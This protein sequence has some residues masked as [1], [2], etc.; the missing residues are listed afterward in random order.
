MLSKIP[1]GKL[2]PPIVPG[3]VAVTRRKRTALAS[4]SVRRFMSAELLRRVLR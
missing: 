1:F 4:V 2:L 3:I